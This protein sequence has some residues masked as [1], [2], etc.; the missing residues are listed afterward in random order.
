MKELGR[1]DIGRL[2]TLRFD[3]SPARACERPRTCIPLDPLPE[4]KGARAQ[5]IEIHI[6]RTFGTDWAGLRPA[7]GTAVGRERARAV[8]R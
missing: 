5:M 7:S 6:Q 8:N 4:Q 1:R 2:Q 3:R